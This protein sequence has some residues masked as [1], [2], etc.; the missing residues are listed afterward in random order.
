MGVVEISIATVVCGLDIFVG[1]EGQ[2]VTYVD[3]DLRD[4]CRAITS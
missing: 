4:P 2:P 3:E 1:M